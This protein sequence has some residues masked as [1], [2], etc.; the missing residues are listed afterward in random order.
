MPED[1]RKGGV[2]RPL[3]K[4]LEIIA[5]FTLL[6]ADVIT[7]ATPAHRLMVEVASNT[8]DHENIPIDVKNF[9]LLVSAPTREAIARAIADVQWLKGYSL[10][11]YWI[12]ES[13]CLEF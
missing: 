8:H 10:M 13:G 2:N 5:M 6:K 11:N 3:T 1:Q 7:P 12:P 4:P 9:E